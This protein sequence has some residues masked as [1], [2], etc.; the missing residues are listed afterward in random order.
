MKEIKAA[1][2]GDKTVSAGMRAFK[3]LL[4]KHGVA[5]V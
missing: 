1:G 3:E 5:E 4:R 2:A